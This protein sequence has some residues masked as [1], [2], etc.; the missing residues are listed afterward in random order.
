M[1]PMIQPIHYMNMVLDYVI[2]DDKSR[3][4]NPNIM[5][6]N[7]CWDQVESVN[8]FVTHGLHAAYPATLHD[9]YG[10]AKS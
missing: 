10:E 1:F 6:K 3:L 8:K 2:K 7:L 5:C 9:R 4:P